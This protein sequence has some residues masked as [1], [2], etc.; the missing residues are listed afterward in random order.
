[1]PLGFYPIPAGARLPEGGAE[2]VGNKS[3]NLMRMAASGLPVPPGFVLPTGWCRARSRNGVDEIALQATLAAG[4][5]SL[6]VATNLG[7][8]AARRP[9]L[10]SVR[11]GAAVSMPG[12]LETVLN[13]GLNTQTVDGLIRHTGSPRLAWD[14]YRRLV[15]GYAEVVEALP[16][17][18]FDAL[19]NETVAKAK[20]SGEYNSTF[21][22]CAHSLICCSHSSMRC[23][24]GRFPRIPMSNC[25]MRSKPCSD[26]G[27]RPKRW[28]IAG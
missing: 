6:E 7:F 2:E 8:G 20:V 25:C 11:S 3:W 1:M 21:A 26:P 23:L 16:A 24:A 13:V 17:A 19:V 4:I 18:S 27:M 14:S 12:M 15:Q 5:G 10:V 28:R 9:L 22:T